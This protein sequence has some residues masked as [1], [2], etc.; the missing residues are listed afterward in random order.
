MT[1]TKWRENVLWTFVIKLNKLPLNIGE[2]KLQKKK[3]RTGIWL[4]Y[5]YLPF[6]SQTVH[7][8]CKIKPAPIPA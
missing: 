8:L 7:Y 3:N 4:H 1:E 6:S 2:N 5:L